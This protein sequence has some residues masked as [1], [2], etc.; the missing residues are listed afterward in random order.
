MSYITQYG[1]YMGSNPLPNFN[2]YT[3]KEIPNSYR[4]DVPAVDFVDQQAKLHDQG[5]DRIRAVGGASLF[6]DWGTTPYDEAA[7][8]A[9][10]S[11]RDNNK[12]GGIDP[13]NGLSVTKQSLDAAWRGLS[14]FNSAVANKKE[15][16]SSFMQGNYRN[17]AKSTIG[18]NSKNSEMQ[19]N[20]Q[21]FLQKYMQKDENGNWRRNEKMWN[22]DENKNA[23]SPKTSKQLGSE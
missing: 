1:N 10:S 2:A 14:L 19:Y 12:N 16:I 8:Q 21:L 6:G 7:A 9:W 4:Y 22:F 3:G 5:Y 23:T 20:Y 13:Y 11:F 15:A 17:E 18:L